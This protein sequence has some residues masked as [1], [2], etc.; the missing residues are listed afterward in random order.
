MVL[1]LVPFVRP[2]ISTRTAASPGFRTICTRLGGNASPSGTVQLRPLQCNSSQCNDDALCHSSSQAGTAWLGKMYRVRKCMYI[3]IQVPDSTL[4]SLDRRLTYEQK[5][6]DE[7]GC[8]KHWLANGYHNHNEAC[9]KVAH[10]YR[11]KLA[12]ASALN[13]GPSGR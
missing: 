6:Y 4:P 9:R 2:K 13:I 1:S 5:W 3:I 10:S 11:S 7:L 8:R 12:R